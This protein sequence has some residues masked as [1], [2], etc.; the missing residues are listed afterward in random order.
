V[1]VE[2]EPTT[3]IRKEHPVRIHH[4]VVVA[5]ILILVACGGSSGDGDATATP[6]L[7]DLGSRGV[8]GG[9]VAVAAAGPVQQGMATIFRLALSPGM[10]TPTAVRAWIGVAYDPTADGIQATPVAT[11]PGSY[12]ATITVPSPV[13][14]GSHIWVR[15]LF[16][17]GSVIETGNED[18]LLA[19]H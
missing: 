6:G 8:P 10:P 19:G 4:L 16:A 2:V 12:E 15:L 1:S 13:A 9:T 11:A 7:H 18:F 17:D 14:A 3:L 5:I